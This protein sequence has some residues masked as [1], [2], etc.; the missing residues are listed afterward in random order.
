[1]THAIKRTLPFG[2]KFIGFC[3]KCGKE[4]LTA[5]AVAEACQ[6]DAEITDPTALL[7]LLTAKKE[8]LN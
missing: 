3:I 7:K 8:E 1:M 2:T 4:N 5:S 6:K